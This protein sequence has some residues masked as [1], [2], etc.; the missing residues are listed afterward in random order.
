M[1]RTGDRGFLDEDGKLCVGG[2]M[3]NREIKLRG[4]RM[5]LYEIEK[6]MEH[7]SGGGWPHESAGMVVLISPGRPLLRQEL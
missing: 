5:D 3:N 6:S 1:C 4:Y 2:R 7:D